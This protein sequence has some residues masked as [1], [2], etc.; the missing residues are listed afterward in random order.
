MPTLSHSL[1]H[2][3]H[4]F[5]FHCF[6][7]FV[8]RLKLFFPHS[9]RQSAALRRI[10]IIDCR[11][12][13]GNFNSVHLNHLKKIFLAAENGKENRKKNVPCVLC[14]SR[15]KGT[16]ERAKEIGDFSEL[17]LWSVKCVFFRFGRFSPFSFR[18]S[19]FGCLLFGM[20]PRSALCQR[21][22]FNW[23]KRKSVEHISVVFLRF[24]FRHS[25]FSC[26]LF[27]N[28]WIK[29]ARGKQWSIY[30]TDFRLSPNSQKKK[31]KKQNPKTTEKKRKRRT[32]ESSKP[33]LN[34]TNA[35]SSLCFCHYV[36]FF[37]RR[38]RK[39]TT[40]DKRQYNVQ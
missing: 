29:I 17:I 2:S 38:E 26:L 34:C 3:F 9:K 37:N 1:T 27:Q 22:F 33:N 39:G 11:V 6:V 20:L 32:K 12:D 16:N 25:I 36:L 30:W 14:Q 18:P 40:S 13:D 19:F 7:N 23:M 31:R 24:L 35:F 21:H 28:E 5:C 10:K 8:S 15:S 4:V